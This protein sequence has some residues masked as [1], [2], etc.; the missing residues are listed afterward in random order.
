MIKSINISCKACDT[1]MS[2]Q[3]K[4]LKDKVGISCINCNKEFPQEVFE[5][6]KSGIV[7]LED[8]RS[9]LSKTDEMGQTV[10]EFSFVI[11]N[12]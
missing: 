12:F 3:P 10:S 6:I 11:E 1:T 7:A 9:C 4:Y 8:A 5:K 2:I